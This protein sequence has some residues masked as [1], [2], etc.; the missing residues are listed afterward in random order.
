M[1]QATNTADGRFTLDTGSGIA[2]GVM[3]I[4]S[5]IIVQNTGKVYTIGELTGD[6][7]LG[8]GCTFSNGASVGANTWKVGSLNTDF[9]FNGSITG[10]GTV[11]EK[12]GTG[13]M[14]LKG[15]SDFTGKATISSGTICLNKS[16]ITKGMLGK[17]TLS[18]DNGATLCGAGM[19]ENSSVTVADGA[20]LRPGIKENSTSGTLKFGGHN[21]TISA[22]ATLRFYVGSRSL[23]TKLTDVGT[24][25]LR[26]TVKVELRDDVELQ[27]G[28]EFQLWTSNSTNVSTTTVFELDSI[29]GGLVWDTSD[30]ESGILRVVKYDT[31]IESVDADKL[32]LCVIYN[33]KGVECAQYTCRYDEVV[34]RLSEQGLP[35]GVYV[36]RMA[37]ASYELVKKY[38]VE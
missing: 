24:L 4:P 3:D 7:K 26:G 5:G 33:A 22:G 16:S 6:G 30:I 29:G 36:V 32:L 23:Y 17:G 8:A 12:L 2:N 31:A 27:E 35:K 14:T 20:L 21:V 28:D 13:M 25:S 10:T 38:V 37:T 18:I 15:V 9:T 34:A 19:L 11:F 1:P